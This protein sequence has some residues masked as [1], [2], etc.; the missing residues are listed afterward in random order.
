MSKKWRK[1]E[2]EAGRRQRRSERRERDRPTANNKQKLSVSQWCSPGD[3]SADKSVREHVC[4]R[5]WPQLPAGWD[6][7]KDSASHRP[8]QAYIGGSVNRLFGFCVSYDSIFLWHTGQRSQ[9]PW[10]LA[11]SPASG[12][13]P[14][15]VH[16]IH[17]PPN[18]LRSRSQ[19]ACS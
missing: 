2:D 18:S 4:V 3:S 16:S 11:N 8:V 15:N 1:S 12:I 17:S 6:Q 13:M 14:G 19:V 7:A 9:S 5:K 10:P